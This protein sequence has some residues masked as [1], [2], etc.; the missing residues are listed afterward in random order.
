MVTLH[1]VDVDA[2]PDLP[3][4]DLAPFRADPSSAAAAATVTALRDACHDVG[5]AH[6]VGHGV[7]EAL[8][9]AVHDVSRRF[10]ALPDADRLE[11]VN[12]NSPYFR[13]YTRLG[14][15][16]T[17]GRSDWRDQIDIG[18][19]HAPRRARPGDPA[20]LRLR[21][22]N[23]WPS[24]LPELRTVVTAWMDAMA[25][26]GRTVLRA[27]ALGLGQP[28]DHF[29]PVV[30][31]DPEVLVKII[32][33]PA[34]T[35]GHD[36][37]QGVGA[38]H[39]SG[40]LTFIHQ[41]DIGGLE[42]QRGE[43]FVPV[44]RRRDAYVLNLGEM[45]QLATNGYLRATRHR[46][47]SPPVGRERVS[48][49]YFFNPCMEATLAPIV[50]PPDLAAQAPGGQNANPDDPVFATYG[51]NWLKFRLRSH[52]DVAERHHADLLA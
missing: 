32:R 37:G 16:H 20:W 30:T 7:D 44:V 35:E 25:I 50:L 40:L 51:D 42:V 24:A 38:H 13:G 5:F 21:G 31:P 34:P 29:E 28:I 11:I 33:Y 48:V 26:V 45:L 23:Q 47:V 12:T 1:R 19:E 43:R 14:H 36:D 2:D 27:L 8:E 39:D 3:V 17:N 15:E 49:A 4:V 18:P 41:D 6:V 22:P 46:V 10:F 9:D 52:P